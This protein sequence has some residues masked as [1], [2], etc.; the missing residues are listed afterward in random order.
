MP[1]KDKLSHELGSAQVRDVLDDVNLFVQAFER[2][3]VPIVVELTLTPP[4][5][6][7]FPAAE[8]VFPD[9]ATAA[10]YEEPCQRVL[11]ISVVKLAA[12]DDRALDDLVCFFA[13]FN[14]RLILVTLRRDRIDTTNQRLREA[15]VLVVRDAHGESRPDHGCETT[16]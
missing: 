6:R 2:F 15:K 12:V 1:P 7:F 8:L 4:E 5:R 10:L 11:H 14:C 3:L 13:S 9:T 16:N